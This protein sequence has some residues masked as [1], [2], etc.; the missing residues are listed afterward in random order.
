[1]KK[2]DGGWLL[3]RDLGY[4]EAVGLSA[5]KFAH[6]DL[7]LDGKP[8]RLS[9]EQIRQILWT[10]A[11]DPVTL[12]F[13]YPVSVLVRIKGAGKDLIQ[14]VLSLHEL[15][16]LCR[17]ARLKDG[18]VGVTRQPNPWVIVTSTSL[19]ATAT[20]TKYFK[21]ITPE[22]TVEKYG[23]DIKK[24]IT[25]TVAGGRLEAVTAQ[26]RRIEGNRPTF[27][28]GSELGLWV[29]SQ[30]GP[31]LLEAAEGG[32]S[33]IPNTRLVG[34]SNAYASGQGSALELI[35]KDYEAQ[36]EGR[37]PAEALRI[38][39]DQLGAPFA[40][41]SDV[42]SLRAGIEHARGDAVWLDVDRKLAVSVSKRTSIA[43]TM[44]FELCVNSAADD[45][46]YDEVQI[47][48][49]ED[50]TLRLEPRDRVALGS[51]F[52]LS[53]DASGLV[54]MRIRDRAVFRLALAERPLKVRPEDWEV[55][56]G[57][58]DLAI[59]KAFSE[60]RVVA[61]FSDVNPVQGHVEKWTKE[62]GRKLRVGFTKDSVIGA[63]MRGS[64]RRF[65][66]AHES[67]QAGIENAEVR[68]DGDT[69]MKRHFLNAFGRPN[70]YGMSFGK[71]TRDS[72]D[73][74]DLYAATLLA[75]MARTEFLRAT[76]PAAKTR[77]RRS[78]Y[79]GKR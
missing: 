18:R 69:A 10:C 62:Y 8:M 27:I 23:I 25:Y 72:P 53:D 54:A 16:G 2:A 1:M 66:L 64:Q 35:H 57:I 39:Y 51:D 7:V 42:E 59:E 34:S 65:T 26:P 37:A 11:V 55:D 28:S 71:R 74:V 40:D 76:P 14:A 63:D 67:L 75:D 49:C 13:V 33:K 79:S 22:S 4:S 9:P 21:E 38:N 46:L 24:E 58:F 30:G 52:S 15:V 5:L 73:K 61:W 47:K 68:L 6:E 44:R 12:R 32:A 48:A 41:P 60:L 17:P 43:R 50:E 45:A 29:P 36:E 19:E 31:E 20:T 78:T 3:P 70:R 77:R 56:M